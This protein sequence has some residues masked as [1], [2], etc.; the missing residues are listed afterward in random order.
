MNKGKKIYGKGVNIYCEKPMALNYEDS[1]KMAN[2][3]EDK[4]LITQVALVYR[5][6]P[7]VAKAKAIVESG[8]LGGI[9]L[10][11]EENYSI[12]VI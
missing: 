11:L 6:M 2:L 12:V 1:L 8:L 10:V 4:G 3:A 5:F 9:L 7:A